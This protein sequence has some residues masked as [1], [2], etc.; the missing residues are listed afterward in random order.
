MREVTIPL[1]FQRVKVGGKW[2]LEEL[3]MSFTM[4]SFLLEAYRRYGYRT[5]VLSI[6][7]IPLSLLKLEHDTYIVREPMGLVSIDVGVFKINKDL[8]EI[9][10]L[11][12]EGVDYDRFISICKEL[13]SVRGKVEEFEVEGILPR[14]WIAEVSKVLEFRREGTIERSVL[15]DAELSEVKDAYKVKECFHHLKSL[16]RDLSDVE[17][18]LRES[19]SRLKKKIDAEIELWIERYEAE[20]DEVKRDVSIRVEELK[21]EMDA[22]VSRVEEWLKDVVS[23]YKRKG[24][25]GLSQIKAIEKEASDRIEK[26]REN[27]MKLIEAE[28]E[29]VKELIRERDEIVNPLMERKEKINEAYQKAL[30]RLHSLM[31]DVN[32]SMEIIKA[33]ALNMNL[34][35]EATLMVPFVFILGESDWEIIPLSILKKSKGFSFLSGFS[36]PLEPLSEFWQNFSEMLKSRIKTHMETNA[37]LM[38]ESKKK[39]LLEDKGF[40]EIVRDGLRLLFING[41]VKK[42][43]VVKRVLKMFREFPEEREEKVELKEGEVVVKVVD[44]D[45]IPLKGAEVIIEGNVYKT[46]Q[47][48]TCNIRLKG[49]T[50]KV[51]VRAKGYKEL[52]DEVSVY[53]DAY[54]SKVFKL[55]RYSKSELLSMELPRIIDIVR[56]EGIGSLVVEEY[57]RELSERIGLDGE[58]I[59]HEI[60]KKWLNEMMKRG[61]REDALEAAILFIINKFKEKGGIAPFSDVLLE[62]QKVGITLSSKELERIL[63]KFIKRGLIYG[64]REV[65]GVKIVFFVSIGWSGDTRKVIELAAKY[66]GELTR[67]DIILE[68]GWPED[69]VELILSEMEKNGI[70][71]SGFVRGKKVWW[72]PALY[73]TSH[74]KGL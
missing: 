32:G 17:R 67:E 21:S 47:D 73:K 30:D 69:K 63:M 57:V 48:G 9:L 66:G 11:I 20:M 61:K 46:T 56:K 44:D 10:P 53:P 33:H 43:D 39:N 59:W 37:T 2:R 13:A 14:A 28:N 74:K 60:Y 16:M 19:F 68:T 65:E 31:E 29:R 1:G 15:L 58:R 52:R 51:R 24:K 42:E 36:V 55:E 41:W 64:M 6:I 40:Q 70:A 62:M 26:I 22:Q 38:R 72:F 12:E 34:E 50:Y 25:R 27:Y 71:S 7:N 45:G 49:G 54:S 4:A 18:R 3:P 5:K 23:Y 35:G 8:R